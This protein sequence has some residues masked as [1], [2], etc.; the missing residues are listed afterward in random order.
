MTEKTVGDAYD[1]WLTASAS[2]K[3]AS[4]LQNYRLSTARFAEKHA[5]RSIDSIDE[6]DVDEHLDWILTQ[7]WSKSTQVLRY[8]GFKAFF[9]WMYNNKRWIDHNPTDRISIYDEEEHSANYTRKAD[10]LK[11]KNGIVFVEPKEVEALARNVRPPKIRNELMVKLAYQ[12]G[13][14]PIELCRIKCRDINFDERRIKVKSAKREKAHYRDVWFQESLDML[15][16]RWR[17]DRQSRL[18]D[19]TPFFFTTNRS[20][21]GGSTNVSPHAFREIVVDA[22]DKA[23]IQEVIYTK[24]VEVERDGETQVQ[25]HDHRR[26]TP[27]ALRHG[28]AVACVRGR[29]GDG[30]GMDIRTLQMLMGHSKIETTAQYLDFDNETLRD[31]VEKFGPS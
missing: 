24:E 19:D 30:E 25:E 3:N 28:F 8:Q 12:T 1:R 17:T 6:D 27:H 13:L 10:E 23:G 4:T 20:G 18:L 2:R 14:R 21:N 7:D 16:E 31:K 26:V 15:M 9:S 11:A 5:D 29:N 22:A